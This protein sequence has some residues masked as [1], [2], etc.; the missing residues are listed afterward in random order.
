M[1]ML[2][3]DQIAQIE[4]L[5]NSQI[6]QH[7]DPTAPVLHSVHLHGWRYEQTY[8]EI[9]HRPQ[10]AHLACIEHFQHNS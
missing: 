1:T 8:P 6:K 10:Q 4:M 9:F 3:K 7:L 5:C 2:T